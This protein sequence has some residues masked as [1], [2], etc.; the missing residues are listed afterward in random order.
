MAWTSTS[1]VADTMLSSTPALVCPL[2]TFSTT[3]TTASSEMLIGLVADTW[4]CTL[5]DTDPPSANRFRLD[6]AEMVT[7][8]EVKSVPPQIVRHML[9]EHLTAFELGKLAREAGV[10][11]LVLSHIGPVG[12]SDIAAIRKAFAGRIVIGRDLQE[13]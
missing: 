8:A 10:K 9:A 12:K 13:L 4:I 11:T 5:T 7:P 2:T 6:V 3:T 1:P